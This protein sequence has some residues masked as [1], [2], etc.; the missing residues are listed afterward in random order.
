[1]PTAQSWS[2]LL[3]FFVLSWN[4]DLFYRTCNTNIQSM[5][6]SISVS[7][8]VQRSVLM[9][10][11][12]LHHFVSP[13]SLANPLSYQIHD[14]WAL[15]TPDTEHK[16]HSRNEPSNH[17]KV[18]PRTSAAS[19]FY[20]DIDTSI[21][22]DN[23]W[24]IKVRHKLLRL[25]HRMLFLCLQSQRS[26]QKWCTGTN[27]WCNN[28]VCQRSSHKD[29][30]TNDRAAAVDAEW[31]ENESHCDAGLWRVLLDSRSPVVAREVMAFGSSH[32]QCLA[33]MDTCWWQIVR[34][35]WKECIEAAT[36]SSTS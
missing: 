21:C 26:V 32:E 17:Y 13:H 25:Q 22:K 1:M 16:H 12:S 6:G 29:R 23:Q 5:H 3:F 20:F 11:W 4:L 36:M 19:S 10:S 24:T 27:M 14:V 35:P 30:R 31:G 33:L 28:W 18:C 7:C 2:Y 8:L 15:C 34:R 9:R